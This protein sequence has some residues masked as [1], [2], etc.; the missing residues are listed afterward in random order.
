MADKSDKQ[1]MS[2]GKVVAK[3]SLLTV[4]MFGFG[5]LLV[6]IY[7]VICELTGLNGK[8]GGRYQYQQAQVAVDESREVTVQFL[9]SNN[10]GMAWE[11]RPMQHQVTLHPGELTEV[12]FY[13]RNPTAQR[14]IAQAVPSV[15]PARSV[16]YLHKTEC[17][18]FTQQALDAG[19]AVEMPLI[20]F[21]DRDLPEDVS[22]LTLSYTL[23]DVT[24]NFAGKS[25]A[26]S[27]N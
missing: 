5:F 25:Q 19:E 13:A 20:F 4:G 7:S 24:Q 23:F 10:A 8:T 14:M 9:A 17:F 16:D 27:V 15:A 12:K 26:L 11:F 2:S 6:P 21:I 1:V 18:C 3:L 22:K